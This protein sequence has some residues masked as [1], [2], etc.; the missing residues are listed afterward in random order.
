MSEAGTV[1]QP[2]ATYSHTDFG[3]REHYALYPDRLEIENT[4]P[5]RGIVHK[6]ISLSRCS[7]DLTHCMMRRGDWGYVAAGPIAYLLGFIVLK[8][9]QLEA[10]QVVFW[11]LALAIPVGI[12]GL[13]RAAQRIT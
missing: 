6:R 1:E 10:E 8:M 11:P 7:A 12:V 4:H 13:W 2:L 5:W 9:V 3:W